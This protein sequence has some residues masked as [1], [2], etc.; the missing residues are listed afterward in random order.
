MLRVDRFAFVALAIGCAFVAT[1]AG[2]FAVQTE[3][4][5][6]LGVQA[7]AQSDYRSAANALGYGLGY[8]RIAYEA[9]LGARFAVAFDRRLWIG[10]IARVN[11]HRMGSIYDGIDPLWAE[12]YYA[13]LREEFLFAKFPPL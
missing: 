1:S 2:A 13:A 12:G 7:P 11:V 9:E 8:P 4:V 10:P 3:L 6:A 5:G